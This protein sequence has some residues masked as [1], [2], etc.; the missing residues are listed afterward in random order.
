VSRKT[1]KKPKL[2][3]WRKFSTIMI[4]VL[5]LVAIKLAAELIVRSVML[6]DAAASLPHIMIA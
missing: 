1:P 5:L 2:P 6:H 4:D 3:L